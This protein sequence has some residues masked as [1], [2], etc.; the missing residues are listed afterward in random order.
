MNPVS[1]IMVMSA[2]ACLTLGFIH[3]RYWLNERHRRD[4]LAITIACFSVAWITWYE[5]GMHSALTPAEYAGPQKWIHLPV[6]L[7]F[8]SLAWFI[9]LNLR[10]GRAWLFWSV[11]SLRLLTLILDLAFTPN[12]HFREITGIK[13]VYIWGYPLSVAEG[14]RNP[15]Q[16]VGQIGLLLFIIYCVDAVITVWRRGDRR[17]AWTVGSGILVF[18]IGVSAVNVLS[19]W[20]VIV[21]PLMHSPFYLAM[22]IALGYELSYDMM[23]AN[24]LA[25]DLAK[26]EADRLESMKALAAIVESSDDGIISATLDGVVNTWNAG[27]ERIFGY[28]ADEIAGKHI[29]I[30]A[31]ADR[32]NEATNVLDRIGHSGRVDHLETIR[33]A[34][35]GRPITVLLT[36]SPLKDD[37][38]SI[39]GVSTIA[40]DMT[41]KK[42]AEA[43]IRDSEAR[44]AGVVGSA[45][46]AIVSIDDKGDI[47]LF[48]AA[49]E[50]M[51]GCSA[52]EVM[53]H[54]IDRFL[55][56]RFR[57]T[58]LEL[59][60]TFGESSVSKRFV[61]A[62]SP[63][64]GKRA[65]GEEFPIEASISQVSLHGQRIYTVILRDITER[66]QVEE[67]LR[68]SEKRFREMADTAPVLI[69]MSGTDKL[70][71]YF[72][73]SWLDFTGRTM[74]QEKGNGW[75]D[76]VHRDDLGNCLAMYHN[77]FDRQELFRMEYRL[78][79]ADGVYRWIYDTGVPRF[80][81]EGEFLGYI[82]S[83]IDI[84]DQ[85]EAEDTLR[86]LS[87]RLIN[88]QERERSRVARELHDDLSQSLALL[89]IQLSELGNGNSKSELIK[90]KVAEF[91]SQIQK[92][93][94]DVHRISH[95]LHPVKLEQL[96]LE[97]ALRGFCREVAAAHGFNVSFDAVNI[98]RSMP[99]D[100]SL[101]LYRIAQESLQNVAKHSSASRVD[102]HMEVNGAGICLVVTDNGCGF[103]PDVQRSQQ[104]LGLVSMVERIRS[105]NGTFTVDSNI[106]SGTE[107]IARIPFAVD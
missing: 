93:S 23:N 7:M 21:W 70:C 57:G 64:T 11:V 38:G 39:I 8:W 22:L 90:K 86:D 35:D 40:R 4:F 14:V 20:G 107:I 1:V 71:N 59:I 42:A 62:E 30:L 41:Q 51:F 66:L 80:T 12:I 106:G 54:S 50:K 34:K 52:A 104:S 55:P 98:P 56:D 10:A 29:S 43:E 16:L 88:A 67:A 87:G 89:S 6:F 49:A 102:I 13:Q 96:G 33:I 19:I 75:A 45:M 79:R 65:S 74:Q 2:A 24:R 27:A 95:E 73:Q 78:R 53:G 100:V 61:G 17:K 15:W 28:T 48:N 77:A 5:I 91:T 3:L 85:K 36:I 18:V 60:R 32:K 97:S 76:G 26:S 63:L 99:N 103:D 105:V 72:N 83:C 81:S 58:H 68:Q 25:A 9:R 82:G 46:D 69:W 44:L 94:L 31:A 92:L 101:C 47:I 37:N 84:T